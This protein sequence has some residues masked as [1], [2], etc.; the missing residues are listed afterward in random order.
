MSITRQEIE[1]L[2]GYKIND[3]KIESRYDI[4]GRFIGVDINVAPVKDIQEI[5]VSVK[6]TEKQQFK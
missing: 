1:E 6:I 3:F 2:L 5:D 4:N